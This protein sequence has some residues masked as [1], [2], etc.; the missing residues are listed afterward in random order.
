MVFRDVTL[1]VTSSV[2]FMHT[3]CPTHLTHSREEINSIWTKYIY[4][5]SGLYSRHDFAL[6]GRGGCGFYGSW[7]VDEDEDDGR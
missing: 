6:E 7:I 5:V 1:I 4:H 2:E 3:F